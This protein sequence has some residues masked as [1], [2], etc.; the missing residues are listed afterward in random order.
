MSS[1]SDK[2][3]F[4]PVKCLSDFRRPPH[5]IALQ[6]PREVQGKGRIAVC[7][8]GLCIFFKNV[9]TTS[10]NSDTATAQV[11]CAMEG[12]AISDIIIRPDQ[13]WRNNGRVLID[14]AIS[15]NWRPRRVRPSGAVLVTRAWCKQSSSSHS[16]S[17]ITLPPFM[18]AKFPIGAPLATMTLDL[19]ITTEQ[20]S[21]KPLCAM[22]ASDQLLPPIDASINQLVG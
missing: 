2:N 21:R 10:E 13:L 9:R 6:S 20:S 14:Q 1:L 4:G 19:P 5:L 15:A 22:P 16:E 3:S 18:T 17:H 7:Q 8:D 12:G 11:A